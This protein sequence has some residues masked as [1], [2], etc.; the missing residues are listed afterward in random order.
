MWPFLHHKP[1]VWFYPL[2]FPIEHR[3]RYRQLRLL[4]LLSCNGRRRL[5]VYLVQISL[6]SPSKFYLLGRRL[7][8]S[9]NE[10][11]PI[12]GTKGIVPIIGTHAE[13]YFIKGLPKS[14]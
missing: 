2:S 11:V 8:H 3:S 13:I 6:A 9:L 10:S 5:G 1:A 4:E 14:S 7:P 12:L